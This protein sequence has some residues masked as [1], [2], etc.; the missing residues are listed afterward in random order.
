MGQTGE[1][2]NRGL[3]QPVRGL[4]IHVG[5]QAETAAILLE[6][7]T[8]ERAVQPSLSVHCQ[9]YPKNSREKFSILPRTASAIN[10]FALL[11]EIAA[12]RPI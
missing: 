10:K 8:V 1:G 3:D 2:I 7:R 9:T 12:A 11:L 5:H 4:V 6:M